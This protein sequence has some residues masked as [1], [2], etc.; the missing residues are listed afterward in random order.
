MPRCCAGALLFMGFS[1]MAERYQQWHQQSRP[2][3]RNRQA[4]AATVPFVASHART[5]AAGP[6][7]AGVAAMPQPAQQPVVGQPAEAPGV[8]ICEV[9][10]PEG[11]GAG[12]P[13]MVDVPGGQR[14][15]AVVPDGVTPGQTFLVQY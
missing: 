12:D 8:R 1:R 9:H 10:C 7:F 2:G 5:Q 3:A 14:V 4:R 11:I 6:A 15:Q 13:L